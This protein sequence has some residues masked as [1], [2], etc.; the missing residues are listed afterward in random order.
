MKPIVQNL[1][2]ALLLMV[3]ALLGSTSLFAL[4]PPVN[5]GHTVKSQNPLK[6]ELWFIVDSRD[7]DAIEYAVYQASGQTEDMSQFTKIGTVQKTNKEKYYYTVDN[8][9]PGSYTFFVKSV[10]QA[11]VESD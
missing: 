9:A 10:D 6:V 1:H 2:K 5:I 8:L 4:T 3:I 7:V 11:G